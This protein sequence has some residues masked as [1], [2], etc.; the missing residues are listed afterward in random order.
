MYKPRMS[1][2]HTLTYSQQHGTNCAKG[3]TFT[4]H[5]GYLVV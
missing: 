2:V 1:N 4:Q 3:A 5:C